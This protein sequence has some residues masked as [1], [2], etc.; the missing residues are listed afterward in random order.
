MQAIANVFKPVNM[1][2]RVTIASV[3]ETQRRH[4]RS[5]LATGSAVVIDVEI[6][7]AQEYLWHAS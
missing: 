2:V 3:E 5:L 4:A 1:T 7:Q 6:E